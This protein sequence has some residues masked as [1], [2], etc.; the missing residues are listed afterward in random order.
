MRARNATEP[1]RAPARQTRSSA[2][3]LAPRPT[4]GSTFGRTVT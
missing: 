4:T 1:G 2:A 3:E